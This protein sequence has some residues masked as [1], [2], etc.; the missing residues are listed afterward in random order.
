MLEKSAS[1]YLM[2]YFSLPPL[3]SILVN[4][5]IIL[6]PTEFHFSI[7]SFSPFQ[8]LYQCPKIRCDNIW[9]FGSDGII[10]LKKKTKLKSF[11]AFP[12]IF[13]FMFCICSA[14]LIYCSL[15]TLFCIVCPKSPSLY[16]LFAPLSSFSYYYSAWT[17]ACKS[18]CPITDKVPEYFTTEC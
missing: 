15:C 16:P 12:N 18:S 3:L 2:K 7:C 6:N 5:F 11:S 10:N 14:L 9:L 8:P 1:W 4:N 13:P 17:H